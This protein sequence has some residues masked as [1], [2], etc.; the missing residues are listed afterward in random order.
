MIFTVILNMLICVGFQI[1]MNNLFVLI[2]IRIIKTIP[3][4]LV[5]KQYNKFISYT[6]DTYLILNK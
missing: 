4:A 2:F 5:M 6:C 3:N 1:K